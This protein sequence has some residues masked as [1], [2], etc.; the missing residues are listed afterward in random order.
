MTNADTNYSNSASGFIDVSKYFRGSTVTSESYR[1]STNRLL[2]YKSENPR[3]P[4]KVLYDVK[5]KV[6]PLM[7]KPLSDVRHIKQFTGHS[8]RIG[9]SKK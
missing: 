3:I 1:C 6:Q 8:F 4:S 2:M 9:N 5:T 7:L